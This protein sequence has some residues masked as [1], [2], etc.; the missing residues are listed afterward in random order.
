M[1]ISQAAA[2][3]LTALQSAF[4]AGVVSLRQRERQERRILDKDAA[5]LPERY[6]RRAAPTS[7][8]RQ[9]E[10]RDAIAF[11][12]RHLTKMYPGESRASR[13]QLARARGKRDWRDMRGLP[14][15]GGARA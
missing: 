10:R 14:E 13:R 3:A 12:F 7:G 4:R 11:A 1:S 5:G 6:G 9:N 8:S 2:R 15:P